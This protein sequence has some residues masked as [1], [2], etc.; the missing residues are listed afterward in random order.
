M[1]ALILATRSDTPIDHSNSTLI[2]QSFAYVVFLDSSS[3]VVPLS[4]MSNWEKQIEDHVKPGVLTSCVYYGKNRT[5][6]AA[7]LKRFDIVITT[8][9][10]VA[11]EHDIGAAARSGVPAAKK[12]KTDKALFGVQWKVCALG[13]AEYKHAITYGGVAHRGSSS[14]R[15]IIFGIRGRRW[16]KRF[17]R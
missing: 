13:C 11:L 17:A 3:A 2:G 5:M 9:Q 12:Q 10:T 6:S 1:L 14:T 8:Y 16:R 7:E 15:V 4:V